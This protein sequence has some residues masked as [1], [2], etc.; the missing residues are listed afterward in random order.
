LHILPRKTGDTG[1]YQYEP[2]EF[3]YWK[4]DR[5]ESPQQELLSI[6]QEVKKALLQ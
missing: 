1:V 5:P 3:I 6:T 2:R 4:P